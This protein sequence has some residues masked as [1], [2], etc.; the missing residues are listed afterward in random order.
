MKTYP[1]LMLLL[2][3]LIIPSVLVSI[4]LISGCE[5]R[6]KASQND[7]EALEMKER[8]QNYLF[9]PNQEIIALLAVKYNKDI[10]V[11][12]GIIDSYLSETDWLYKLGKLALEKEKSSEEKS[13]EA[14][15]DLTKSLTLDKSVYLSQ[16]EKISN[17]F[18]IEQSTTASI[19]FDYKTWEATKKAGSSE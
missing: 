11:V 4:S 19:L 8:I 5:N 3:L 17:Q 12:E 9:K 16:I 18:S 13:K 2:I 10:Q 1:A 7:K 6:E 14:K 15:I